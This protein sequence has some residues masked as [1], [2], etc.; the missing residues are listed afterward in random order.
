MHDYL[1]LALGNPGTEYEKTR[2]N[3]G[4]LAVDAA[5][6]NLDWGRDSYAMAATARDGNLLFAKPT[7]FM[8][9]SGETAAYFVSR[10]GIQP[11]H[12]IVIYDDLD[13]P[14]G[15][16]R[17]SFDRGSGGHNG[18]KSLEDHLGSREFVRVRIGISTLLDDG[19]LVKRNV[20]GNF[21]PSEMEALN[22]MGLRIKLA[23][24]TTIKEGRERAMTEFNSEDPH[25]KAEKR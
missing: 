7:T 3:A 21:E 14:I 15:K 1:I 4:W 6:P 24:N 9:N 17:I 11:E 18:I 2:H 23:I 5:Y 19:T 16:M 22:A 12:I 20:L 25:I 10:K 8:N 13:L